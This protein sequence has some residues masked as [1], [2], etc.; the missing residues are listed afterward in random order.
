[1]FRRRRRECPA[2]DWATTV[3]SGLQR[4]LCVLCGAIRMT[5][6]DTAATRLPVFAPSPVGASESSAQPLE[7]IG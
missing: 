5:A 2:H 4:D 3:H 1:M 7:V 6:V